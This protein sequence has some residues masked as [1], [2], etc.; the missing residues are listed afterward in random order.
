MELKISIE[1]TE[2]IVCGLDLNTT[3]HEVI[4]ALAN[5]LNQTGRFYLIENIVNKNLN[6]HSKLKC[7]TTNVTRYQ[8]RI[9]APHE[10]PIELLNE[11]R[12]YLKKNESLEFHLFKSK[13]LALDG[14]RQIEKRI[15]NELIQKLF[16]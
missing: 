16:I 14:D 5:S 10:K 15:E 13:Y 2:L 8:P 3:V 7:A 11:S 1:N 4:V 9:M 12:T 6:N